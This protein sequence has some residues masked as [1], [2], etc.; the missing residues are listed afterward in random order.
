M[1]GKSLYQ[2]KHKETAS[3][4]DKLLNMPNWV[5]CLWPLTTFPWEFKVRAML[6]STNFII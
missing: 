5:L 3:Y 6:V 2:V 1:L 4:I